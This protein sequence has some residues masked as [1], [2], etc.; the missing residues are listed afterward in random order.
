MKNPSAIHFGGKS[1]KLTNKE[2]KSFLVDD[3]GMSPKDAE[4][5]YWVMSQLEAGKYVPTEGDYGRETRLTPSAYLEHL[6]SQIDAHGVEAVWDNHGELS[7]RWGDGGPV[8]EYINTGDTYSATVLWDDEENR[9]FLT[10]WGDWVERWEKEQY[11]AELETPTVY[12]DNMD[13]EYGEVMAT[14]K[15]PHAARVAEAKGSLEG[16]SWEGANGDDFRYTII[17]DRVDL[18]SDLESDGWDVNTD[19]YWEPDE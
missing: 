2:A 10:T 5:A 7:T 15:G 1:P 4:S 3:L 13:R 17:L 12:L 19:E 11:E 14:L 18:V 9:F 6:N 8:A 16:S